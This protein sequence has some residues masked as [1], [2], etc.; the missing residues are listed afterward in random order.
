MLTV[1]NGVAVLSALPEI[2]ADIL[3][4][5]WSVV[6]AIALGGVVMAV[7]LCFPPR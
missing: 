4:G 1:V 5:A 7:A 3:I 2:S 6:A